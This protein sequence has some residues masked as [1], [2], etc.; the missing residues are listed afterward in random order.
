MSDFTERQKVRFR[1]IF[2]VPTHLGG[3][4]IA[5]GVNHDWNTTERNAILR[6]FSINSG[7]LAP[8]SRDFQDSERYEIL[9]QLGIPDANTLT[10]T[11]GRDWS[12]K[13]RLQILR[14]YGQGDN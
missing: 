11:V 1:K 10:S 13:Q 6:A 7:L 9:R 5:P 14:I 12:D 3:A 2:G 4:A 8:A